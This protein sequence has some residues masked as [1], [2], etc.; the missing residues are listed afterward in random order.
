M[1]AFDHTPVLLEEMLEYLRPVSGGVYADVT[2]GGGGHAQGILERSSPDGRL[3]GTD[4]DPSALE[5][6]GKA[7]TSYGDRVTL[8]KARIRD[9]S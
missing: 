6:A 9:L 3:V 1:T 8:R 7:L 4:R 5:A 2:L